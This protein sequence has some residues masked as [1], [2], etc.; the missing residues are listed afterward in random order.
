M[1]A[2]R[3]GMSVVEIMIVVAIIGLLS[4][5]GVYNIHQGRQS[6]KIKEAKAYLELLSSAVMQMSWDTGKWPPG[7]PRNSAVSTANNEYWDLSLAPAGLVTNAAGFP[8]W[9]GPYIRAVPPRDPWGMPYFFDADYRLGGKD[10]VVVGSFG[11]NKK[12]RNVYD[13]D[14]IVVKIG[15]Y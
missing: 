5:L 10:I 1:R 14:D 9:K 11:P 13:A 3:E 7:I 4:G 15:G 12:G 2:G 6:S 8:S